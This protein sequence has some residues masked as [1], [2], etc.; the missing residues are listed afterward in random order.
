[1]LAYTV[2]TEDIPSSGLQWSGATADQLAFMQ[3]VY[4]RQVSRSASGRSFVGDVPA[5]ELDVIES[6]QRARRAAAAACRNLLAAAR[7]ALAQDRS[8]G[9][10]AALTADRLWV[11]SGYRSA[12]QQFTN[13]QSNFPNYYAQTQSDRAALAGGAMG[14]A[15]VAF[16][17][18]YIGGRLAAPGYSLHNN[19]L[20]VDFGTRDGGRDLG[21]S[22]N[23]TNID[24]WERSWFFG[25]LSTN[26][27]QYD[28]YQNTAIREPWHWEYRGTT[29]PRESVP[30]HESVVAA[31]REELSSVPVLS[32]HRGTPPD[33]VLRW[34]DMSNPGAI[35]VVV[36]LHGYSDDRDRMVITRNKEPNSG[37][38]NP[39][40]AADLSLGRSRPTLALLPRGNYFGGNSGKGYNF[41]A[42]VTPTGLQDLINFSIEHFARGT[43]LGSPRVGRLILTAHSGGGAD[44]LKILRYSDPDE[45]HVFDALYQNADSLTRWAQQRIRRD[46]AALAAPMSFDPQALMRSQGGALRVF[47]RGGTATQ[48]FSLEVQRSIAPLIAAS[49]NAAIVSSWYRVERTTVSHGEIPRRYGWQLLGDASANLPNTFA[50]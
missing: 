46:I 23:S 16:L 38:V 2:S 15:A 26:A 31:G 17:A 22:T 48:A 24:R 33:L 3:R 28:Y 5:A 39:A 21:A 47:Y 14:D 37:L 29:P 41:P 40:N 42:L 50:P 35:D 20:A 10:A 11:I 36:H 32:S 8:N 25:W 9:V 49:T 27:V 19:G 12:S 45:V 7:A 13:W 6:G 43:G 18:R 30:F 1:M 44:L 4:D 34:N